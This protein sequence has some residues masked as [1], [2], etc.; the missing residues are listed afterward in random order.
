MKVQ[1]KTYF[2]HHRFPRCI[3]DMNLSGAIA[4]IIAVEHNL[5]TG[6]DRQH[7]HVVVLITQS[8]VHLKDTRYPHDYVC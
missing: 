5:R 4:N 3:G 7:S 6:I 1:T 8:K 2:K